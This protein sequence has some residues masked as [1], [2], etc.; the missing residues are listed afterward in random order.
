MPSDHID[1]AVVRAGESIRKA[2]GVRVKDRK[3]SETLGFDG[4]HLS[5]AYIPHTH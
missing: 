5:C 2:L 1:G 3:S 4:L